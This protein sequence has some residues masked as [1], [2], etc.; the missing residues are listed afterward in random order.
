[1]VF[2]DTDILSTFS[3]IERLPLLYAVFDQEVLN[4][5]AAV[6][7]EIKIGASKGFNFANAIIE[8][9]A[10]ARIQT[11]HPIPVD[12]TFMDSLPNSLG[13]G[14]RESM[15]ICKRVTALFASN[16]RRVMHHC[17][18]NE[19]HCTNLEEILRSL[20]E[21]IVKYTIKFTLVL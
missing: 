3:K 10:Q 14:E 20:W 15:A 8:L 6:E 16:E 2:I 21:F 7:Y 19:I 18:A 4:I 11:Y 13:V 1:M 5:A 17:Q 9:H 12:K